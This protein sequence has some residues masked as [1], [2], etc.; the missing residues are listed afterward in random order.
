MSKTKT[1]KSKAPKSEPRELG[2]SASTLVLSE[3][4]VALK[5]LILEHGFTLESVLKIAV[6]L[7]AELAAPVPVLKLV[8]P[9]D[10]EEPSG[11]K[12]AGKPQKEP[13]DLPEVKEDEPETVEPEELSRQ[14][15][16]SGSGATRRTKVKEGRK[17]LLIALA[18]PVEDAS[19][20]AL[21][22]TNLERLVWL[23]NSADWDVLS[24]NSSKLRALDE[25]QVSQLKEILAG[26]SLA[27]LRAAK[28]GA[29]KAS[30]GK[31]GGH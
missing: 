4:E 10:K 11:P 27:D 7:S 8:L 20:I 25:A 5:N 21:I 3:R 22:K 15:L 31:P 28:S 2:A 18:L 29:V 17:A 1:K 12:V 24:Q 19:R 14:N 30:D 26:I 9:S 23:Q 16:V 13:K 6:S